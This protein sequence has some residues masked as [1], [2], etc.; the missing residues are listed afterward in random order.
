M[1]LEFIAS[2]RCVKMKLEGENRI[3]EFRRVAEALVSRIARLEGVAG[4]VLIGGLVRGFTDRFSDVDIIVFLGKRNNHLRE[5]I[6]RMGAEEQ[7]RTGIDVDLEVHLLKDFKKW[8]WDE[9][10][11]W[12]FSGS[13]VVFDPEGEVSG[14]ITKKLSAPKN[15]WIRRIIV[16]SEY[17]KW[18]CCP[19]EPQTGSIAEA[20]VERGDLTSA[21]YC[22]NYAVDLLLD[23]VFA[24][25]KKHLPPPKWRIFYSYKLKWLPK[26][27]GQ[28]M[29]EAMN[30]KDLSEEDFERRVRALRK[31]WREILS[32]IEDETGLDQ[33]K[34]SRQYAVK[35]LNQA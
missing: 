11:R 28:L 31:M 7:R 29:E 26:H 8:R 15:F 10:L 24:L 6:R 32:K 34:I 23:L 27:Y 20:W 35:I 12:D 14:L 13:E 1:N 22:L 17:I 5:R 2:A 9:T 25:N 21:H 3:G 33:A 4:I 30:C 19:P 18:Y 16:Y